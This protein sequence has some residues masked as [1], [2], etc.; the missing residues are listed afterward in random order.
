M[1]TP[2]NSNSY[3]ITT[4]K[5][6]NQNLWNEWWN[7]TKN[8]AVEQTHTATDSR[9]PTVSNLIIQARKLFVKNFQ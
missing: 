8:T 1:I 6:D 7:K 3:I 9:S 5:K 4:F 2:N